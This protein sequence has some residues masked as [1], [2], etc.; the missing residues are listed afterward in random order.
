MIIRRIIAEL[1]RPEA[2]R[3]DWLAWSSNQ[4]SHAFIGSTLAGAAIVL[5]FSISGG[6]TVTALG[7]AL[8]KE[9]PDFVREPGWAGARDAVQD[10]LFVAGGA[11]M[12][13]AVAGQHEIL[14]AVAL[15]AVVTGLAWGVCERVKE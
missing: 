13:A 4:L 12:M 11:L 8:L 5:G 1:M 2:H 15:A 9:L 14:F 3:G 10:A 7:Y 6:V